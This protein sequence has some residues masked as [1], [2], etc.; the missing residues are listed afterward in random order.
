[1]ASATGVASRGRYR[2][3][4]ESSARSIAA[5]SGPKSIAT[6][7]AW[8]AIQLLEREGAVSKLGQA[9][10]A[11]VGL[12][13]H[14]GRRTQVH[15]ALLEQR[16]RV[17]ELHALLV[18]ASDDLLEASQS[19]LERHSLASLAGRTARVVAS[20]SPSRSRIVKSRSVEN[21]A[22]D[23]RVRPSASRIAP[24]PRSSVASGLRAFRRPAS[25]ASA[26]S[27]PI[28]RRA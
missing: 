17:A 2:S 24:Y 12:R 6:S 20:T 14:T 26:P 21:C 7:T 16:Q 4:N 3:Q 13:Q 8:S 27:R 19:L 22:T 23:E 1:M 9:L 5:R 28:T 11:G 10:H 18:E 25:A 15:D